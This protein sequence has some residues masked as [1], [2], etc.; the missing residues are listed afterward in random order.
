MWVWL[1]RHIKSLAVLVVKHLRKRTLYTQVFAQGKV[2]VQ[3]SRKT[4][5]TIFVHDKGCL[6]T[7]AL[8]LS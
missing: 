4:C 3:M 1:F 2:K 5:S 7:I 6:Y 8:Q